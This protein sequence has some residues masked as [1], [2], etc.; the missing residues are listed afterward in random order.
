MTAYFSEIYF[1]FLLYMVAAYVAVWMMAW[2][3]S[4]IKKGGNPYVNV[5]ICWSIPLFLHTL[6][7]ILFI[8]FTARHMAQNERESSEIFLYILGF[9]ILLIVNCIVLFS[10]RKS[11]KSIRYA[12]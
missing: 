9:I 2:T 4:R 3:L 10:F 5:Y 6:A 7:L 1:S 11:Q 12:S 8:G